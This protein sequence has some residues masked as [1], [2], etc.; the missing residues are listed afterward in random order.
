MRYVNSS[1]LLKRYTGIEVRRNLARL[2]S[3]R[4]LETAKTVVEADW[5]RT[6]VVALDDTTCELALKLRKQPAHE[7]ST[8]STSQR[9]RASVASV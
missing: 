5:E 7:R 2:L 8:R 6:L 3:G 1:A 9:L 4:S